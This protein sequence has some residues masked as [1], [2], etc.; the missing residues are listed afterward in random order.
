MQTPEKMLRRLGAARQTARSGTKE[1][2]IV[3]QTPERRLV[4]NPIRK[5]SVYRSLME[6]HD[7]MGTRHL[8]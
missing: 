2:E 6:S 5:S 3:A 4:A 1:A 7:R 8:G